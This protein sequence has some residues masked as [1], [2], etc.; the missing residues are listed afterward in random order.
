MESTCLTESLTLFEY[1]PNKKV[2]I[3]QLK[4][5]LPDV[6][7]ALWFAKLLGMGYHKLSNLIRVLFNTPLVDALMSGDHSTDLQDYIVE[8]I[9][10]YM[11]QGVVLEFV[12]R[13]IPGELLPELWKMAT[14]EI[15]KSIKEVG[16]KLAHT[17][18]MLPS[19]EGKM[20]FRTLA[21]ANARRPSIGDFKA[22]VKHEPVPDVLVIL[23]VSG[24]MSESTIREIIEDVV[25]MSW[26]A[27]AS[28][29]I[30]SN[31]ARLWSP[32]AYST[33]AVLREAEYGGTHYE[34]LVPV[35]NWNWGTVITIADYDS[36]SSA[37]QAVSTSKGKIGT[38][39][40]ISLVNRTTYLAECVGQLAD[41]VQPLL[42]AQSDLT[43]SNWY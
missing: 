28:L 11:L 15:A 2:S 41:K 32:G 42:I 12:E 3:T 16:T 7:A 21:V 36:S 20:L 14:V 39:L 1:Q 19:K 13:P 22:F 17:L 27:N 37:K 8:T 38:V 26:E 18:D 25:S 40:D 30:V 33:E 23:D 9:P 10:E 5:W 34:S 31:T 29:C 4:E 6:E 24:S 43:S 35:L